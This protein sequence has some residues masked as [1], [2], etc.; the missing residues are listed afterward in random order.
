MPGISRKKGIFKIE[1]YHVVVR[2]KRL[3]FAVVTSE[4]MKEEKNELSLT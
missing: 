2:E 4:A 3:I 1:A